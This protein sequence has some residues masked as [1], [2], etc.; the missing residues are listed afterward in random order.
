M[1]HW[2]PFMR[3]NVDDPTLRCRAGVVSSTP[4]TGERSTIVSGGWTIASWASSISTRQDAPPAA[5]ATPPPRYGVTWQPGW[6]N[7]GGT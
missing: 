2:C 1:A 3:T 6:E 5:R 7:G 4:D